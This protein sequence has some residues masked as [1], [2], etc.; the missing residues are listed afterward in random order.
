MSS[1][2]STSSTGSRGEVV[3]HRQLHARTSAP[4][5][6]SEHPRTCVLESLTVV[7][8]FTVVVFIGMLV[9][10]TGL[11]LAATAGCDGCGASAMGGTA[12]GGQG[13]D[14]C[15]GDEQAGD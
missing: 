14:G 3:E 13:S 4:R 15:D 6:E 8:V 10:A 11:S 1:T 5:P 9:Q 2:S 12:V 7:R